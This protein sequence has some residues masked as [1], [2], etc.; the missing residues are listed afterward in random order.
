[1]LQLKNI[2]KSINY[3]VIFENLNLTFPSSGLFFLVGE[4][5]C[6]KSTLLYIIAGLD[7]SY[8]GDYL[9]DGK[10]MKDCS[11]K[12]LDR[13]RRKEIGVLFSH[14]NLFDFMDVNENRNFDL[15]DTPLN[16]VSLSNDQPVDYL[17]G[18]EELLLAMENEF[19]KNKKIYLLDEVTSALDEQNLNAVMDILI[20]QSKNSLILMATHDRRIMNCAKNILISSITNFHQ[21][22]EE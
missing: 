2:Y 22:S 19:A 10:K 8:A 4:N 18:G 1:M 3:H 6:G 12:E 17:S 5:G 13:M 14:G 15:K 7:N 20:K 11:E 16:L 21:T 9:F